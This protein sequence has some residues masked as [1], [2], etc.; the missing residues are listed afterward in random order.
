MRNLNKLTRRIA[1]CGA[2]LALASGLTSLSC[3][4]ADPAAPANQAASV[5]APDAPAIPAPPIGVAMVA[6]SADSITLAWYRAPKNDASAYNVYASAT[7]DGTYK[8]IATV[9]ERTATHGKLPADTPYFYK[10]TAT[11]AL[12]ESALSEIAEGFTIR[13]AVD[14]PFPARIAKNMCVSLGAT[15]VTDSAPL[16]GKLSDLV[17]GSDATSCRLRKAS[18]IKIKLNTDISI[19][20]ADYLMMNFRAHGTKAE[21]SNDP[22]ARTLKNYVVIESLD[23]TDGKDGAW[24]EVMTGTNDLLDGVLVLPNHKP[25]WIG[26]RSSGGPEIPVSDRRLQPSDLMLCRLDIF[27]SAPK[28]FRN[29]YWIF[30]GD[31]LIVQDMPG[32][33]VEGRSAWFSDLVRKQHP[34]RYPMVV[35]VGRGGTVMSNITELMKK[36]LPVIAASNG[37]DT[38]TGTFLCFEPGFNDVGLMTGLWAGKRFIKNLTD[39]Q[40]VCKIHGLFLVPVR[41]EYATAYLNRETQEP[42]KY[43]LFHNTLAANLGGVDVFARANT[44]YAVNPKTQLP[45]ADYWTYTHTNYT[46]AIVKDGVHHTKEGSD[47]INRLWAD[48]ADKMIYSQQK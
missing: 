44:P 46:T 16:S 5:A 45:Y 38:P 20:D 17:D 28:G 8:R 4:T 6:N 10:V 27:R 3:A 9:A 30:T 2:I 12:G 33:A 11:N 34:D 40:E 13:P 32:G 22:L 25:K 43:N 1:F 23:S 18:E 29:D 47:G 15:V 21:W 41:I 48:V 36:F 37:S 7:K 26:L 35:H 31:S 24:Q 14:T 42:A 19:A 39:A